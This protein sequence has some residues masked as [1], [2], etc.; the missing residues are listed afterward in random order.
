MTIINTNSI[1]GIN[2]ITAQGSSGVAF[3]DS[4]GSSERLRIE[5]GG[6]LLL[7][8]TSLISSSVAANFQVAS[9]F[10]PRFNIARS[11]TTTAVDN[12]IGAFDFYGNDSNGVYQ[13][14][15][16]ILA[17]ADLDHG[18]DDKPTRLTFYTTPDGTATPTERLRIASD[19]TVSLGI[20]DTASNAT[21]HIRSPNSSE[22]TRL[23]LSTYD[24]FNGSKPDA[25]I[26]F[27]QQNGTEIA[28]IQCDTATSAANA[29]DLVFYTNFGG[30]GERLRIDK[31]GKLI[32]PTGSPG[33]QF[34]TNDTGTNITSQTLDDYEE[35]NFDPSFTSAGGTLTSNNTALNYVK[36]GRMVTVAGRIYV[37]GASA[38]TGT[39]TITLPFTFT[40]TPNTGSGNPYM[41][42]GLAYLHGQS[43]PLNYQRA[44]WE[45]SSGTN[46]AA[47]Y[48]ERDN[49]G[50]TTF[51]GPGFSQGDYVTVNIT[52]FTD[53]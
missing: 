25:D 2:S 16:R 19:G 9:D 31:Q 46:K 45:L 13:N 28:K 8:T 21:L 53:L 30:L 38:P 26:V 22:N 48:F 1:S 36:V 44:F 12:L 51:D 15:A 5:S 32:L 33:I 40:T 34:G 20:V 50:W 39:V 6:R 43:F 23:E 7:G 17:E 49:Q 37:N 42:H 27:T 47:L 10:G 18:T 24:T 14:C 29:A 52:Y 11:D 35:G 41:T 3:F 4:S